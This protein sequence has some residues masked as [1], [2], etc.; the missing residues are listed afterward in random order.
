MKTIVVEMKY[1]KST[2]RTHVFENTEED[3]PIPALYIKSDHMS[4]RPANII[5]EV[6]YNDD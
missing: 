2:K 6:N 5:V 1:K 3:T 4:K